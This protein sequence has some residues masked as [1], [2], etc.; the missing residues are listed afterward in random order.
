MKR[1]IGMAIL[2]SPHAS[3]V[4]MEGIKVHDYYHSS[5]GHTHAN[6]LLIIILAVLIII[7]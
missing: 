4:Y 7:S 6:R 3:Y 2:P 1:I 5:N